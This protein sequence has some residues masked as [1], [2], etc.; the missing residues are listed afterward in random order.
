MRILGI[1]F[2]HDASLCYI[3]DGRI[4]FAIEEEKTS[5]VKQDFGWPRTAWEYISSRYKLKPE[6]IDVIVFGSKFY[7]SINKNEIKYRFTKKKEYKNREIIDRLTIYFGL[8]EKGL[9]ERNIEAFRSSL[10]ELGFKNAKI[11]FENH[12]FSHAASAYYTAPF[13][14][15]LVITCDGHGDGDS[16]M[17]YKPGDKGLELIEGLYYGA[18]VGQFYSCITRLLG[19]RPTR[20]E[21]K[22]TG[23][24]AF[25]VDS[26]LVD[27][28]RAL[29]F[30]EN[31]TLQRFPYG[32]TEEMIKRYKLEDKIT[33]RDKINLMASES[34]T[35]RSYGLNA[36]ILF[37]WLKENTVGFTKENISYAC[38][39]VTEEVICN[40]CQRVFD[41]HF[42]SKKLKVSLAGGVFSNVRVNQ[43][44]YE[45]DW[46]DNIFIQPAMGDS[47]LALGAAILADIH[48]RKID[49]RTR[50]YAFSDTYLGPDYSDNV[51]EFIKSIP[52][53][54]AY[55]IKM[56]NPA[57]IIAD[58]LMDNK[59]IGLWQGRMEWGPRALG[60]RS[61]LLN[62]FNRSVNDSLNKRLNRTEFMPFA[63][64][65]ID[66][67]MEEY[68]PAYKEKC[69]A[70]NYMT[71]T[72][73]VDHKY[74]DELQAVVHV[75]GTARPQVVFK[76][77]NPYLYEI[78]DTFHTLSGCGAIVNTSFNA[79]EEP[80]VSTPEIAFKALLN[81]RIDILVINNYLIQL[82]ELNR[83]N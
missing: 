70:G 68:M 49:P 40:E 59:I 11:E 83:T 65:V 71:I 34:E 37:E 43:K 50:Q 72:Y 74:H 82:N 3:N 13:D 25:G 53:S 60:N 16:L 27:K 77:K 30:Y 51:D 12:H 41:K 32:Q 18:S 20:H 7:S 26:Q 46:V 28:F 10:K 39:K 64:V 35:G 78:L 52:S 15:D 44:I 8:K 69:P 80:I 33:I 56:E 42:D 36:M 22:I 14:S 31:G 45:L 66:Y 19:F 38:Q 67:K 81:N 54:K 76:E 21:G 73:D 2:S 17:F 9:T 6:E 23:L 47:G 5:R 29:F 61:I 57:R 79:H 63:P 24:A 48:H 62:T 4:E 75:D 55:V 58:L 1:N